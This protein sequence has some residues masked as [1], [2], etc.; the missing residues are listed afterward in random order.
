MNDLSYVSAVDALRMF[1][2]GDLSPVEL[3][4][5]IIERTEEVESRINAFVEYTFDQAMD[6]AR[7]AEARYAGTGP[8]PRLLEGIP[9]AVKEEH[10][11]A[12]RTWASGSLVSKDYVA[13]ITH[14]IVERIIA[15]GASSTPA[16]LRP[17]S[18]AL[19][20]PIAS[21][22]ELLAILGT[23]IIPQADPRGAQGLPWRRG[24]LHWRP[25][26]ISVARSVF[27]PLFVGWWG[28][29]RH[30]DECLDTRPSTSITTV[31]TA[32]WPAQ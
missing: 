2:S 3:M 23:L 25:A 13:D 18:A 22:G 32:R 6:Q 12:G 5:S 21:C 1:R 14:P 31:E 24:R 20:S 7:E 16:P 29:S 11:I 27:Q 10:P 30:T 4:S 8:P 19:V 28:T 26:L 15:A 9:V 17:S